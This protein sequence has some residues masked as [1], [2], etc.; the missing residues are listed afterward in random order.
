VSTLEARQLV[1]GYRHGRRT[2]IV[3]EVES[4][5]A[6]AGQLTAVI[7][8]NG[9]GKSTLLRTLI[10]SQSPL[11]GDV[12]LD[13]TDV[14]LLDRQE[15]ARKVAVVLTDRVDPGLLLVGDIVLLGRH[16]HTG[17]RGDLTVED[18]HI[19]HAAATRLGVDPLWHRPFGELSDGQRQRV[20]VARALAQQPSVLV[21][22]EPTAFLDIAGR[23][24][25]TLIVADLA[26]DGL[27]VV[28]ST[29]DL[30]LA[31]SHA[32]RVWL[33]AG[34]TVTDNAPAELANGG[35]LAKAFL[36]A[37]H[38][39]EHAATFEAVVTALHRTIHPA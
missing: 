11:S 14:R 32:D 36:P 33:V 3:V 16:P 27:T 2:S 15:R 8:P 30:D 4:L 29:H 31:L 25:L 13:G 12:L 10:G 38:G 37:D 22:D 6:A 20:L 1:A 39:A 35:S 5:R 17:W 18:H 7:G 21:L 9:S 26:R 34:A 28:V 23:V 19:A 24:E